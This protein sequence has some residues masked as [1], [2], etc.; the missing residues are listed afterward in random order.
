M[1]FLRARCLIAFSINGKIVLVKKKFGGIFNLM[2]YQK[3]AVKLRK[4]DTERG[5]IV[6]DSRGG[7]AGER[8][9]PPPPHADP[10]PAF[11]PYLM[12]LEIA[13]APPTF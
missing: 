11:W 3:C 7:E 2:E 13:E 8:T 10:L 4:T 9:F 6:V 12:T 5:G 1:Q